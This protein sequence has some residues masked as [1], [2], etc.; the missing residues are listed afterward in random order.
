MS[1][2][3]SLKKNVD[4]RRLY[5]RGKTCVTPCVVAYVLP[6]REKTQRLGI[7]AG[8][9]VGGAVSRNRAKRRIRALFNEFLKTE[10]LG[11]RSFDF[12]IVARARSVDCGYDKLKN[13][14][15]RALNESLKQI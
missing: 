10:D 8:K 12:V 13:D 4:F 6:N 11:G 15:F 7:T 5:R 3:V 9:K 1:E 14:F 2:F